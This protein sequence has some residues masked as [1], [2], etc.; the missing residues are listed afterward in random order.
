ME[1]TELNNNINVVTIL[2]VD[3]FFGWLNKVR[4]FKKHIS[5]QIYWVSVTEKSYILQN[6]A[7]F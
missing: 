6:G 2:R 3:L 4:Y 7:A 1:K 5:I